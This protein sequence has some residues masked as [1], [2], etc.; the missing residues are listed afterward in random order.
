MFC[1]MLEFYLYLESFIEN[2]EQVAILAL[3][4]KWDNAFRCVGI[5][6]IKRLIIDKVK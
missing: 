1:Y 5:T 3:N 4:F 2:L 6:C